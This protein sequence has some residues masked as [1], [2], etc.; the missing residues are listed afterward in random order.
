MKRRELITLLGAAVAWPLAAHAQEARRPARLGYLAPASNPDLQQAFLGR[1]RD[2]GYVEGQNLA[3]EYRFVLGQSK[4]YDELAAELARLTPDAI[5]VVGT[6]PA[7]AAKRQTTTVPI[8]MAPAADPL[9]SGLV[10]SLSRPGGNVTG[11][12]LYGSELARK[13]NGGFQGGCG[14]NPPSRSARQCR[15]SIAS[16]PMG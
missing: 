1:L 10:A 13:R 7:L 2:L 16:L 5:V 11:V 14:R 4:T 9:R 15:K 3:I 6:P 12:S 8:I